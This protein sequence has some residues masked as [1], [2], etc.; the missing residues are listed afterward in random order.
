M[1]EKR[2]FQ[3]INTKNVSRVYGQSH[4]S[5]NGQKWSKMAFFRLF[6]SF[7]AILPYAFFMP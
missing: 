5:E 6:W 2:V 7:F 3:K 1:C 4:F